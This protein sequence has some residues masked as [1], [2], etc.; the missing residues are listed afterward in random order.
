MA[1]PAASAGQ[2][3]EGQ[4]VVRL[5][6]PSGKRCKVECGVRTTGIEVLCEV[7]LKLGRA[8]DDVYDT[9]T[10]WLAYTVAAPVPMLN[11]SITDMVFVVGRDTTSEEVNGFLRE[12]SLPGSPLAATA[13]HGDILGFEP[14]QLVSTDYVNDVRSSI[15]DAASTM[16][17]GDKMVTRGLSVAVMARVISSR[18]PA[19]SGSRTSA[20]TLASS[21]SRAISQ[22]DSPSMVGAAQSQMRLVPEY[23]ATSRS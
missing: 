15:V 18:P 19:P 20:T 11:S 12:A 13:E 23:Q 21:K 8:P 22:E 1:A 7:A 17:V 5:V 10:L 3:P 4:F 14:Q 16:V 9:R 2:P 6:L